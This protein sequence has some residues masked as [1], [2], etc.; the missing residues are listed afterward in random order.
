M[1]SDNSKSV[2]SLSGGD[3]TPVDDNDDVD[4]PFDNKDA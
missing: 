1:N 2:A 4:E 3:R